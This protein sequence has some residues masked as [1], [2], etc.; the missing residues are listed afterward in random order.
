MTRS[1]DWEW[2]FRPPAASTFEDLDGHVQN[3]IVDKLDAIVTDEWRAPH[4]HVEPLSGLPHG[5]IRVGDFRLGADADRETK[6]LMI[7]DIEHRSGAYKPGD[8]D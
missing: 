4:E 5:K 8:D 7:Y 6:T 3:R 2:E 1:D